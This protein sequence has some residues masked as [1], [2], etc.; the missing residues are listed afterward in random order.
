[1]ASKRINLAL[2][3][4]GALGAF[5]V[6]ALD[7]LLQ[8]PIEI[9]CISATSAGAVNAVVMAQGFINGGN[10]G[11]RKALIDFWKDISVH[12]LFFSPAKLMPWEMLLGESEGALFSYYFF[13]WMTSILSPYQFNVLNYNP[14][15]ALLQSHVN[16][17]QIQ[18]HSGLKLFISATNVRTGKIKV[19]D[20]SEL[21]VDVILASSCLPYLF[22]SVHVN[23]EY[24]WDGGYMGNPPIFPLIYHSDVKDIVLVH[25]NPIIRE[26]IP[27]TVIE[28]ESRMSEI[29]FNSSVLREI[30]AIS[31]VTELLDKK[32]IK[33]EHAHQLKRIYFHSL[34][35]DKYLKNFSVV[36]RFNTHWGH[37]SQLIDLGREA[38]EDWIK[39]NYKKIGKGTSAKMDELTLNNFPNNA[40][41]VLA[42]NKDP[43]K[44]Y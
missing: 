15:R 11:A 13:S 44:F 24:Y 32:W 9:D 30:R 26:L 5:A 37:L 38:G 19:F 17:A 28:I 8:S 41:Q 21:C 43:S 27:K 7:V 33:K 12:G 40:R 23:N 42:E 1:M 3:G 16:F 35:A 2:Q 34:R 20:Q 25:I 6:G 14:L 18:S 39:K 10:E 22:Q 36:D 4:G 31:F 29:S